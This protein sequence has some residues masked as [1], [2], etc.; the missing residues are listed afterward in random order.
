MTQALK[1]GQGGKTGG[2]ERGRADCRKRG[3]LAIVFR[4]TWCI[5]IRTVSSRGQ[6]AVRSTFAGQEREVQEKPAL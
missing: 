5:C 2:G 1:G 4:N 3:T 6:R